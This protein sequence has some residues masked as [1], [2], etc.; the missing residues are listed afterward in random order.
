MI[1]TILNR[2]GNPAKEYLQKY[3]TRFPSY[4]ILK[5][6]TYNGIAIEIDEEDEEDFHLALESAGFD[7]END[8]DTPKHK[9]TK[10]KPIKD[11]PIF[12]KVKQILPKFKVKPVFPKGI[13]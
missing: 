11:K 12:P 5:E 1:I 2:I 4:E 9:P 10:E 7:F 8:E 3:K 13:R 6:K